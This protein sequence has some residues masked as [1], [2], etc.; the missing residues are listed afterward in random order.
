MRYLAALL[1]VLAFAGGLFAFRAAV[2][3]LLQAAGESGRDLTAAERLLAAA[4][5]WVNAGW[6]VLVPAFAVA[7]LLLALLWPRRKK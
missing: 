3:P 6:F 2:T 7:C 4:L 1:A 5:V